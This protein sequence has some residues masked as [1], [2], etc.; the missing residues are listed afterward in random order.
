MAEG[1]GLS[2]FLYQVKQEILQPPPNGANPLPLLSVEGVELEI[3]VGVTRKGEAGINVHVFE[4]GANVSREDAHIVRVKLA[5]LLSQEERIALLRGNGTMDQVEREQL[6]LFKG[7]G[8]S[9]A[10]QFS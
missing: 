4:L 8:E 10:S 9:L 5:P 3:K 1:I 7:D 6:K 2:Q